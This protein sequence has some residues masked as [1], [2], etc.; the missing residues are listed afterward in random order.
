MPY[1]YMQLAVH[2]DVTDTAVSALDDIDP[3]D[4]WR[5]P[6]IEDGD[7]EFIHLVIHSSRSQD[8]MDAIA[9][10]LEPTGKAW[11]L[12]VIETEALLPEPEDEEKQEELERQD[13]TTAREEIFTQVKKGAHLTRDM[14]LLT[15]LATFVA[16]LGMNRDQV[17]VVIGSMVI[18]PLLG[19]ILAF[20]FG[21]ALGNRDLL[22]I[23]ARTLGAGLGVATLAGVALGLSIE[24]HPESS[25]LQFDEPLGLATTALPLAA[26][27]AAALAIA[28]ANT[29]PLVGVAVAAALL[30]PL[31]GFGLLIGAGETILAVK[32]LVMVLAN[33]VAITLAAQIVFLWKGIRPRT[34]LSDTRENSVRWMVGIWA[35][36]A[37]AMTVALVFFGDVLSPA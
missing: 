13:Q 30:P 28:S 20:A 15:A 4:W 18:A 29:A 25:L 24:V 5:A 33:I 22:L 23:S 9:D 37:I 1:R 26:G 12:S 3:A 36:L 8:V 2:R 34:F 35:A 16:A 6:G 32:A 7:M 19:P 10:G 21:T 11:R 27:S 31:A 17:A 14:L